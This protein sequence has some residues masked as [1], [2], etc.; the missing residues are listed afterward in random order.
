MERAELL[1]R[2]TAALE[3]LEY[4]REGESEKH[5]RD[6]AGVIKVTGEELDDGY[7][8]EWVERLNLE[9]AW[10]RVLERI[11]PEP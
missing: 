1:R 8:D 4:S 6:I 3:E 2:V 11:E 5:L 9:E 10:H 7:I